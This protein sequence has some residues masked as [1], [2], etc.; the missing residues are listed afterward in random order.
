MTIHLATNTGIAFARVVK[1]CCLLIL[2]LLMPLACPAAEV[3]AWKVPLSRYTGSGLKAA[4]V[5]RCQVAPEASPFFKEGDELWD[6]KGVAPEDRIAHAPQIEWLVWNATSGQLVTKAEWIS[7]WQLHQRLG[8]EELPKQ[9][10]LKAS[11]F[12]VAADGAPPSQAKTARISQTWVIRSGMKFEVAQRT[13]SGGLEVGGTGTMDEFGS[14]IDLELHASCFLRDQP[15]L[16]FNCAFSLWSGTSLW[17]ARDFDGKTGLDFMITN[18]IELMDGTPVE[19][20]MM[21]QNADG[22]EPVKLDRKQINRHRIGDEGWLAIQWLYPSQLH[23]LSATVDPGVDPFAE[24][25]VD[26]IRETLRL[27]EVSAPE[28]V[29]SWFN[30][31]VWN[32]GKLVRDNGVLSAESKSFA[33]YDPRT[34]DAFLFTKDIVEVDRFE[35]LFSSLRISPLKHVEVCMIGRGETRLISRSGQKS[36]LRR[37]VG[38]AS[39]MRLLEIE[40]VFREEDNLLKLRFNYRNGSNESALEAIQSAITMESGDSID[41]ME[42][43]FGTGSNSSLRLKAVVKDV[44]R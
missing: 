12:E 38:G 9:C 10:R 31:P 33:G 22:V 32:V 37:T 39:P 19:E 41:V 26:L 24:K 21:I 34:M 44:L 18:R 7:V 3:V 40:P 42:A 28:E 5:I 35:K 4:G 20:A 11:V 30:G 36:V 29:Q 14:V 43:S 27:E 15:K 23:N 25:P 17:L 16:D 1:V 2:S 8:I 6:L 13:E